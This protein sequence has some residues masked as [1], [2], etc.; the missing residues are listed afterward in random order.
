MIPG[1]SAIASLATDAAAGIA[2]AATSNLASSASSASGVDAGQSFASMLANAA[3]TTVGSLKQAE[4]LSIDALQ[5]KA[6]MRAVVDSVMS[7]EQ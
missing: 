2:G 4:Q 6:D 3:G 5:G 1:I 7:A